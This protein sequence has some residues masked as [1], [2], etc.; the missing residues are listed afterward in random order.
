MNRIHKYSGDKICVYNGLHVNGS[1][2]N[3]KLLQKRKEV[4]APKIL[5]NVSFVAG[6]V[7]LRRV[8]TIILLQCELSLKRIDPNAELPLLLPRS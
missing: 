3:N 4:V 7:N 8:K 6:I 1:G 5:T 2:L